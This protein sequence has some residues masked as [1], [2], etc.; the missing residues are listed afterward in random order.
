[1][2][3]NTVDGIIA[4]LFFLLLGGAPLAM[5]YKAVN[6]LDSMVGYN[7]KIP[8]DRHGQRSS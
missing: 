5:A 6:T 4:P 7:T 3:E 2:A 1:M 8:G